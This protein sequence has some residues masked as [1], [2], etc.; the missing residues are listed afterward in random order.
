MDG[1]NDLYNIINNNYDNQ[2]NNNIDNIYQQILDTEENVRNT[3]D[4]VIELKDNEKLNSLFTKKSVENVA[5]NIFK[6]LN[7]ILEEINNTDNITYKQLKKIIKK[8]SRLIYIGIF[9]IALAV[10]LLLIE[11][12]DSL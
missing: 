11:I 9:F 12:S 2:L 6:I 8:D 1:I 10:S 5:L 4:R 7:T 3:I